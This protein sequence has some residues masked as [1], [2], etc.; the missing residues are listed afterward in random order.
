[1]A[2]GISNFL[3]NKIFPAAAP[4]NQTE[5][6]N[7][8]ALLFSPPATGGE[9]NAAL[10]H[11]TGQV[12]ARQPSASQTVIVKR[13]GDEETQKTIV[14]FYKEVL[15]QQPF[16]AE[17]LAKKK[18]SVM[19]ETKKPAAQMSLSDYEMATDRAIFTQAG[20]AML[21]DEEILTA[22]AGIK[23]HGAVNHGN[24]GLDKLRGIDNQ[25]G[26]M[27]IPTDQ[28]TIE[29][30][31]RAGQAVL[32]YREY[33]AKQS[34]A[35]EEENR[36]KTNQMLLDPLRLGG[37]VPFRWTERILNTP[38]DILQ[39][40][41]RGEIMPGFSTAKWIGGKISEQITEQ[42]APQ[43]PTI[44]ESVENLTGTKL[45]AIPEIEVPRPFEYQTEKY[46]H[47]GKIGE[48][49]GATAID[50]FLLKRGIVGKSTATPE[51]LGNLNISKVFRVQGGIP[52]KASKFRIFIGESGEMVVKDKTK[53][54]VTFDDMNRVR[55]FNGVNR[56]GKAEVISFEVKTSFVQQVRKF[57][58]PQEKARMFSK[59][60]EI[61]DKTKT[62]SSFGLPLGWIEQLKASSIRQYFG[63]F[64][65][66]K[67]L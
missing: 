38:G 41:D 30:A 1:M 29:Y 22:V 61:S 46:K 54:F 40:I 42:P 48:D 60:P 59:L 37:N 18:V 50:L 49:V 67:F 52:P 55:V 63:Q 5:N 47:E 28:A 53:L 31:K 11:I 6:G 14:D 9:A 58:V 12:I 32:Q 66:Q 3:T 20:Y 65:T 33:Q 10:N 25:P 15:N 24:D 8:K 16:D 36:S 26:A 44:S 35:N 13:E 51:S 34:D 17:N 43:M 57:A 62:N 2:N 19:L 23:S 64:L 7:L 4:D 21:T 45:P 56:A 39:Q 27:F